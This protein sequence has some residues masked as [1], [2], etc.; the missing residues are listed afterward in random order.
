MQ[1]FKIYKEELLPLSQEPYFDRGILPTEAFAFISYC[2]AF[3]IDTVIESGTAFG[4]SCYLY[5]KYLGID[6]H[7]IDDISHYGNQAQLIAKERCK[8]LP[9]TF[10]EGNSF[11]ILPKLIEEHSD[12][13]IAVFIDGPKGELANHLRRKIW[14][15]DN[16]FIA[17]LHDSVGSN[18]DGK[19]SSCNHPTFLK[20]FRDL[21]DSDSLKAPYPDNP[22]ISIGD[23]FKEGMGMDLWFKPRNIIYYLYTGGQESLYNDFIESSKRV[24]NPVYMSLTD[25]DIDLV[26]D[27]KTIFTEEERGGTMGPKFNA[28]RRLPLVNGDKVFITDIDLYFNADIFKAFDQVIDIGLTTR[29]KKEGTA[30]AYSPINAGVWCFKHSENTEMLFDW[31]YKQLTAPDFKP[32]LDYKQNHPFSKSIGLHEWWVDQDLLNVLYY[33]QAHFALNIK[34]IG[35]EYNWVVTD[36]EF[37]KY[38]NNLHIV[39]HRKGGTGKRWKI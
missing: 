26:A 11:N 12:K 29:N 23:K 37:L 7:T 27:F 39:L 15:Y 32:W 6:I 31:F 25:N 21:F 10:H 19:F 18:A 2:K 38:K 13:K 4:Q 36:D 5:A 14:S 35:P 1:I 20:E 3:Q 24:S 30:A 9:V 8:D 17:A 33:N 28:I 34:D 22:S 16:V